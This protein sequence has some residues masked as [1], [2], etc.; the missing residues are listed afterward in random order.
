MQDE[1]KVVEA[2][3]RSECQAS[4]YYW[5]PRD[6][7]WERLPDGFRGDLDREG[8][9]REVTPSGLKSVG[10]IA[11]AILDAEAVDEQLVDGGTEPS[12][13]PGPTRTKGAT[14][15]GLV[16]ARGRS[17]PLGA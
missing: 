9:V 14:S 4:E 6:R 7:S 12:R 11:G 15:A 13:A 1:M 16:C 2:Y 8:R 10:V 17:Y 5:P 3:L